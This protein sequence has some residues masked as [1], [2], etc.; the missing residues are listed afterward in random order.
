MEQSNRSLEELRKKK[1]SYVFL[2]GSV[3]WGLPVAIIAFVFNSDFEIENMHISRFILFVI[4]FMITGIFTGIMQFKQIE[5]VR[6]RQN[7]NEEITQGIQIIKSGNLW[8]YESLNIYM[9][10]I[11]TLLVQN[12]KFWFEGNTSPERINECFNVVLED[13]QQLQKN[14]SFNE[15]TRTLEVKVQIFDNSGSKFLLFE[16]VISKN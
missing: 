12:E 1:W 3:Y 10:N 15:F 14:T 9:E 4:V 16:K 5:K 7:D 8:S 6:L 13:F 11:E 2:H